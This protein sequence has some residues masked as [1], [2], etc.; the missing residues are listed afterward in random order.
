MPNACFNYGNNAL[1]RLEVST[2]IHTAA[3][4]LDKTIG[5]I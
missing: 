3:T 5:H 1:E 4:I 2:N